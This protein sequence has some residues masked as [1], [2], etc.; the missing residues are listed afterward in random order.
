MDPQPD[1]T[2]ARSV[3]VAVEVGPAHLDRPFDYAVPDGM[4]I[5][6]GSAVQVPF[7]GR[8]RRG[9]VLALGGDP[10]TD[11]SRVRPIAAVGGG[12]AWFDAADLR[13]YRWVAERYAGSLADVLRHA[14][15]PRVARVEHEA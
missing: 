10:P 6:V 9:W 11:L 8:R 2:A 14:L 15:P 7:A 13:L 3:Q 12:G 1:G 4:T 5:E